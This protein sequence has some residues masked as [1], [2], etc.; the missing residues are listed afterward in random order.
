MKATC[1]QCRSIFN[2]KDKR[3]KYCSDECKRKGL[4][5]AK[6][7]ANRKFLTSDTHL[8]WLH[9]TEKG[10]KTLAKRQEFLK[11]RLYLKALYHLNFLYEK[12]G[13]LLN[14]F[15]YRGLWFG[16]N[17]YARCYKA[18]DY[19]VKNI[20]E[21]LKTEEGQELLRNFFKT[22]NISGIE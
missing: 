13:D 14:D 3:T 16:R 6:R 7:N 2:R 9:N 21:Y 4:K 8:N 20:Y 22:H 12:R 19:R 17:V 11:K 18:V 15:I 5:I 1:K 10:R